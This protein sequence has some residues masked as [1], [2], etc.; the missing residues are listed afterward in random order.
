MSGRRTEVIQK[1]E[2]SLMRVYEVMFIISPTTE[3]GDIDKLI[4]QLSDVATSQGAQ[5]TKIDRMGRRRLA[6]PIQK[7]TEG[8]YVVFTIEGTGLEIAELERRMRVT[9]AVIR[10]LTVRIDQELKRAEKFRSARAARA[11]ASRA[12]RSSRSRSQI[13]VAET[14]DEEDEE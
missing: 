13:A 3:E 4:T 7:L 14:S 1:E 9:D 5:V 8:Y 2:T 12:T 6:Y 10:Y 11:A